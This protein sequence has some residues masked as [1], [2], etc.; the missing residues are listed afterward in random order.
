MKT[1]SNAS[2]TVMPLSQSDADININ[3]NSIV[4]IKQSVI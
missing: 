3:E 4:S 1:S 2:E